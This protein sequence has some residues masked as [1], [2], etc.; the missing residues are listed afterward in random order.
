DSFRDFLDALQETGARPGE[1]ATVTSKHV[2]LRI[3]AWILN[4][5]KTEH[6]TGVPRV[7]V[8]SPKMVDLTKRLMDSVPAGTPLFRNGDGLAW[9]TNAI[10]CRRRRAREKLN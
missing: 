3:G 1:I 4:D 2:D 5:H 9:T 7:I 6:K 10:R 8:L